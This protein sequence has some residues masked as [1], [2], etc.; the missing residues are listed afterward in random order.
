MSPRSEEFFIEARDRLDAA[1]RELAADKPSVTVSLAY[2]AM[3]YAA[4]AALSEEGRYARTHA[5]TWILFGE[6]FVAG[7]R[8]DRELASAARKTQELRERSD[9]EARRP[10]LEEASAVVDLAERFVEAV[11]TAIEG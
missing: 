6:L 9:Y 2:Y 7:D 4:R 1:R 5:G 3:L 10:E 11:S 8:V